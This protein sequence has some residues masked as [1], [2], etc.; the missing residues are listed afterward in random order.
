[1]TQET[2]A[3]T[4]EQPGAAQAPRQDAPAGE[5]PQTEFVEALAR[6][7][8]VL[9]AFDETHP[10]MALTEVAR[11]TGLRPA[12]ARRSL[13]TLEALGYVRQ[14]NKRYVLA[15]RVLTLGA[16]YLRAA[17]VDE[18]LMP[19]LRRLV[20]QF[21]DAS[22]VAVLDGTNILYVAHCSE[23]RAARPT[24]AIGATYPGYVTSMGRVLLSRLPP[25]AIEIYLAQL[26]PVKLTDHTETDIGKLRQILAEVR[27]QGYAVVVDQLDYGVTSLAVPIKDQSGRVVAAVNSSGYSGK[28]NA[29]RLVQER[30]V[31]LQRTAGRISQVFARYPAL[32]HSIR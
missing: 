16:A 8:A 14:Y 2:P 31:E 5:R 23:Q 30:L 21:G 12:T 1:M 24:A 17:H 28:L 6:G 13:H 7:L 32:L 27:Q 18:A 19:E 4:D 10:E 9:Q 26:R 11:R 29:E 3:D 22:S 20:S 25:E 15:A